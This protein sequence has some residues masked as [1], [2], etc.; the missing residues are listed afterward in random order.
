MIKEV[1]ENMA[2]MFS[3]MER[4]ERHMS[5][6]QADENKKSYLNEAIGEAF[7]PNVTNKMQPH[8]ELS[9]V[10]DHKSQK[11]E[12]QL[13]VRG[14]TSQ[15]VNRVKNS[16]F[17]YSKDC[18]CTV[19]GTQGK[20]DIYKE[21]PY[22]EVNKRK[23]DNAVHSDDAQA[24]NAEVNSDEFDLDA[25]LA[26]ILKESDDFD[27]DSMLNDI[28]GGGD[29]EGTE[30]GAE[31]EADYASNSDVANTPE[32]MKKA[33]EDI[34]NWLN[35]TY[36]KII[37]IATNN[38]RDT[39]YDSN[40]VKDLYDMPYLFSLYMSQKQD[41]SES[42]IYNEK[43]DAE[44]NEEIRAALKSG[45][46]TKFGDMITPLDIDATIWGNQLSTRNVNK[47]LRQAQ[48]YGFTPTMLHGATMWP[49]Y[50]NR[51]LVP[52][53]RP[54]HVISNNVGRHDRKDTGSKGHVEGFGVGNNPMPATMYDISDTQI[55][56]PT[57]GDIHQTLPGIENNLTGGKN[58][59]AIDYIEAVKNQIPKELLEKAESTG[60]DA[61]KARIYNEVLIAYCEQNSQNVSLTPI[62]D[63]ADDA[64]AIR[65][66]VTNVYLLAEAITK[67][68]NYANP[69]N[70]YRVADALAFCIA[71]Y[72]TGAD[73]LRVS[74]KSHGT[75]VASTWKEEAD[76]LVSNV[77]IIFNFIRNYIKSAF[78][79]LREKINELLKAEKKA[80]LAGDEEGTAVDNT[81]QVQAAAAN[82]PNNGVVN[83][84]YDIAKLIMDIKNL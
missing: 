75:N 15:S 80:Q 24:A 41:P 48:A 34:W 67:Q 8:V 40:S 11:K 64:A 82:Q 68:F 25:E 50:Y 69:Q 10:V 28:M 23:K 56:D 55:I 3:L 51:R 21:I 16:Q 84:S 12:L 83:E 38:G 36:K 7:N 37:D 73:Q 39:A 78:A 14:L 13:L 53:A 17:G 59:A 4:M 30:G 2:S 49:K 33:D 44:I 27:L 35:T 6:F 32:N 76:S 29:G 57:K 9:V 54:F 70:A 79:P 52:G 22:F 72:T 18:V 47:I 58:Q 19:T 65:T 46:Y 71:Y 81:A 31:S 77:R 45:D 43:T 66:Y 63:G 60:T 5:G 26:D 62:N 74:G 61:G 42:R 20:L 1:K